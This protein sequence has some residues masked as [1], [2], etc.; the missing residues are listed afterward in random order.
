MSLVELV[1]VFNQ[2]HRPIGREEIKLFAGQPSFTEAVD[3]AAMATD[4]KKRYRHQCPCPKVALNEARKRLNQSIE[5]LTSIGAFDRL[6]EAIKEILS[7]VWGLGEL[8]YYDT[9]LRIGAWH[10]VFPEKVY[11][12]RGTRVGARALNLPIFQGAVPMNSLPQQLQSLQAYEVEDFLCI[13]KEELKALRNGTSLTSN[14]R[15]RVILRSSNL[16]RKCH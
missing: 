11:M 9:A 7:G 13:Y 3:L 2:D 14:S 1:A 4:G 16:V 5:E 6:H 10:G 15:S 8:Y 12:H